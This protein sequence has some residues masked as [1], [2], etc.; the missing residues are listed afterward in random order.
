[1]AGEDESVAVESPYQEAQE[2]RRRAGALPG[3]VLLAAFLVIA[4]LLWTYG[5]PPTVTSVDGRVAV[6]PAPTVPDVVGLPEDDAVRMLT[7]AGFSV[8]VESSL[9]GRADPGSVDAQDPGAGSI[10]TK[11][12]T[13]LIAVAV[14]PGDL[15]AASEQDPTQDGRG[16]SGSD[17]DGVPAQPR[18]VKVPTL[19]GLSEAAALRKI[20]AVG[21]DP[22]P[23]YQ[24]LSSSIGRVY[25][26]DPA[27]GTTVDAGRK[28]FVLI[29]SME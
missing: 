4:W 20:R 18:K 3:L 16:T 12:A 7:D 9:D 24:P 2:S 27:P 25:Q 1:M 6:A 13:V 14:D 23:M 11:G 26:Q 17:G 15:D 21:L 8:E 10:S 19:E 5:R 29:G 22:R 28:V